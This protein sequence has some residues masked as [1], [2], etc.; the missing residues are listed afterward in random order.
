MKSLLPS[1]AIFGYWSF[2]IDKPN[3]LFYDYKVDQDDEARIAA[4]RLLARG[5]FTPSQI[6]QL[7]GVSPQLVNYWIKNWGIDWR[8]ALLRRQANVWR[9]EIAA[10][11][12]K[13]LRPPTKKEIRA[14][15]I[16]AKAKWDALQAK[17]SGL[18]SGGISL[19]EAETAARSESGRAEGV[20]PVVR[21]LPTH[22]I[23]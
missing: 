9:R 14:R 11:N 17:K 8:H 23:D 13:T 10:I 22:R 18:Q 4:L 1:T 21:K 12:G 6:A 2:W 16:R 3:Q 5:I 20:D 15:G 7:A 19:L